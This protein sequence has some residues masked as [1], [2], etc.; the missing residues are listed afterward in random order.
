MFNVVCYLTVNKVVY[1]I[2]NVRRTR[3]STV[4]NQTFLL[5]LSIAYLEQSAPT[6]H[7]HTPHTLCSYNLYYALLH[8][9]EIEMWRILTA[10][11]CEI[12]KRQ[13]MQ[14]LQEIWVAESN[15]VIVAGSSSCHFCAKKIDTIVTVVIDFVN[16]RLANLQ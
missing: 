4:G 3:L 14:F 10:A 15:A 2:K 11:R 7:V 1:F 13:N 6:C 8:P 5:L 9:L 16:K 12:F